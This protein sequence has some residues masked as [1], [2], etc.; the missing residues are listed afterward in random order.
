[1]WLD[2]KHQQEISDSL[3][4]DT[5]LV[6]GL[7]GGRALDVSKFVALDKKPAA[8]HGA[9]NRINRSDYPWSRSKMGRAEN[10][11]GDRRLA[12][13]GLRPRFSGRRPDPSKLPII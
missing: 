12:M 7:G 2:S 10:R 6:V 1:M 9:N 4:D 5:E 13:G 11:R 8:C 3:P